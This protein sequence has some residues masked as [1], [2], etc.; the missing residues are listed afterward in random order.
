LAIGLGS[1]YG[2]GN[3]LYSDDDKASTVSSA[4]MAATAAD[5]ETYD[6]GAYSNDYPGS[7]SGKSSKKGVSVC[8]LF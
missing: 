8:S 5:Y 7:K 3:K 2:I 4:A 6:V 1:G